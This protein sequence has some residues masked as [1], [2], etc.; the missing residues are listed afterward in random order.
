MPT[1]GLQYLH[2]NSTPATNEG[3]P[4]R[5][6]QLREKKSLSQRKLAD[7]TGIHYL[8]IGKY[9]RG[10]V[11]PTA[12]SLHKLAEALDTHT[13]YL[14]EGTT[15]KLAIDRLSDRELL[16]QFQVIEKLD[17]NRKAYVKQVLSD[18]INAQKVRELAAG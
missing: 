9:E 5:L 18:L 3:F 10:Q 1:V 17:E 11:K 6:R 12:E 13:D 8:S 2:M 14:F 7:I 4:E 15:D 16:K